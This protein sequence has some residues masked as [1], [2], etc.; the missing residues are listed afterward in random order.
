MGR[1]H[2]VSGYIDGIVRVYHVLFPAGLSPLYE[3]GRSQDNRVNRITD[4]VVILF[5]SCDMRLPE[6]WIYSALES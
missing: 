6:N 4:S 1:L 5:F 2:S 3:G